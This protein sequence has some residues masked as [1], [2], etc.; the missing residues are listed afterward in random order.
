MLAQ[1][2]FFLTEPDLR[3]VAFDLVARRDRELRIVKVLTN[4]DALSATVARDLRI[5]STYLNGRP[6]VV[7]E[8]SA[9]GPLE[10]GVV[11]LRHG[12]PIVEY[13]TLSD[14]YLKGVPPFIFAA[15]GGPY[16]QMN[17]ERLRHLRYERGLSLGQLADAA[18]VS[19]KAI[20]LYEQGK[21]AMVDVAEKLEEYLGQP[22]IA[23]LD[24]F[25]L[26]QAEKGRTREDGH[27]FR[28]FQRQVVDQ[29]EDLG[30]T[31]AYPKKANI[32]AISNSNGSIL[33]SGIGA[34]APEMQERGR[35]LH[36]LQ[37]VTEKDTVLFLQRPGEKQ[38]ISGTPVLSREDLDRLADP[39]AILE[40]VKERK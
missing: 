22:M 37:R 3:T 35:L 4:I 16:V 28:G 32:E 27:H 19:R 2:G 26:A 13:S 18:G 38:N 30:F 12:I 7:G 8:R 31:M 33:I 11:Y 5:L 10:E 9:A 25:S 20:Q 29:L 36:Q 34:T 40:L 15:P 1:A 23:P 6:M 24:P 21:N 14:L 17:G 39:K